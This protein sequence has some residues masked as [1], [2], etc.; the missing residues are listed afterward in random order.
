MFSFIEFI[1]FISILRI[2][3]DI[4]SDNEKITEEERSAHFRIY[5]L[6]DVRKNC[7][8]AIPEL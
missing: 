8:L 4:D 1:R 5:G 3:F 7:S 2:R 6:E